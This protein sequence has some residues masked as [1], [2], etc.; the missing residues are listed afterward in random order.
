MR[1]PKR[2]RFFH[3]MVDYLD[4]YVLAGLTGNSDI[5]RILADAY[6]M[7]VGKED[8]AQWRRQHARFDRLCLNAQDH[9]NAVALGV[10]ATAIREGSVADAWRWLER[11]HPDF[12]PSSKVDMTGRVEGLGAM[13][14]RRMSDDELKA[15][16]VL[17]D[18][19]DGQ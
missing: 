9:M 18:D 15:T 6:E 4:S 1:T 12:K 10:V 7:S 8:V 19:D 17:I 3:G 5:A 16:G 14:A 2:V 11:R 13:L